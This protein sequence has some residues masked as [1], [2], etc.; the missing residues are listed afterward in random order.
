MENPICYTVN[1]AEL[2]SLDNTKFS[3]SAQRDTEIHLFS[4]THTTGI[5]VP[6]LHWSIHE[7]R[8]SGIIKSSLYKHGFGY[9]YKKEENSTRYNQITEEE[10]DIILN[11]EKHSEVSCWVDPI[12]EETFILGHSSPLNTTL[13][14]RIEKLRSKGFKVRLI[15]GGNRCHISGPNKGSFVGMSTEIFGWRVKTIVEA[16]KRLGIE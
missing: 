13:I 5:L 7:Y 1:S 10:A 16:L 8:N 9:W 12:S 3:L 15:E 11:S 4:L 2:D 6:G 14:R